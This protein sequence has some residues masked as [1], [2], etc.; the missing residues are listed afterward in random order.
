MNDDSFEA[1]FTSSEIEFYRVTEANTLPSIRFSNNKRDFVEF[2]Q[3]DNYDQPVDDIYGL[4][5]L[6]KHY[7]KKVVGELVSNY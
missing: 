1:G 2:K 6:L 3:E 5:S 7:D 4:M